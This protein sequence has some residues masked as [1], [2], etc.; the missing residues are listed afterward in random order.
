MQTVIL[1]V[2]GRWNALQGLYPVQSRLDKL[3]LDHAQPVI[4]SRLALV[5]AF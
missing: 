2:P 5:H 3:M 1:I 4:L